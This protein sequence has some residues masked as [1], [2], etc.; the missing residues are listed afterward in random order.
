MLPPSLKYFLDPGFV[1]CFVRLRVRK[2]HKGRKFMLIVA[3]WFNVTELIASLVVFLSCF[4]RNCVSMGSYV[5]IVVVRML[6]LHDWLNQFEYLIKNLI[7]VLIMWFCDIV[8]FWLNQ[9]LI[10]SSSMCFDLQSFLKV[11]CLFFEFC[12]NLFGSLL[13]YWCCLEQ[14]TLSGLCFWIS[15]M[16]YGRAL[17]MRRS[18]CSWSSLL[19]LWSLLLIKYISSASLWLK[20]C[21]HVSAQM[22]VLFRA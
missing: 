5:C 21:F 7:F 17:E 8:V 10:T 13:W 1:Y 15:L 22:A 11:L 6:Q 18:L 20:L 9:W 3:V 12:E 2:A 4:F 14:V 19:F 16:G